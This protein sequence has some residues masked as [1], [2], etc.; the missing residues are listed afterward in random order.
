MTDQRPKPPSVAAERALR[1]C[2]FIWVAAGVC[3]LFWWLGI[4]QQLSKELEQSRHE[5]RDRP[6]IGH[7]PR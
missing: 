3:G 2:V 5:Q 6:V 1:A 7:P 4:P